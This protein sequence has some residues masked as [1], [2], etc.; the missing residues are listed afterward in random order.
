MSERI[1]NDPPL[2]AANAVG[3][4]ERL[5]PAFL[6]AGLGGSV[7][8]VSGGYAF[9][10][11]L[12]V[13]G[14]FS[15]ALIVGI[16]IFIV[17]I[18]SVF[19]YWRH[20]EFRVGANEIRIDSGIFSRTHRSIPFDRIQDVDISQGVLARLFGIA[21]VKLETGGSSGP[22]ADEGVLQ[23]IPLKRAEDLR[24][25]IRLR[26][27]A[28]PAAVAAETASCTAASEPVYRMGIKRLLLAGTFNFSLALFAG[29]F[30][31]T[32]TMGDFMGFDPLSAA[33]WQ[34][35][36]STGDPA[37]SFILAHQA[38][39]VIAGIILLV[40][41][42]L[43]TGIIRTVVRDWGFRLDRTEVGLRRRR[44]LTTITDV[45]L[46]VRRVQAAIMAS[47]PLRQALGYSE[48]RVQT[49]GHD[50]GSGNHVVAP[51]A[52]GGETNAIVEQLGWRGLPQGIPWTRVSSGYI[53]SL[54]VGLTPLYLVLIVQLAVIQYALFQ[55]Q[56][57]IRAIVW[58]EMTPVLVSF[59]AVLAVVVFAIGSR[60]LAWRTT[61]YAIDGDRLLVRMGWWKKRI[62]LLPLRRIQSITLHESFVT[63][64]FGIASLAFGVAGGRAGRGY[65][66]PAIPREGAR[67]LR[68]RLLDVTP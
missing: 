56:E 23:A 8:A 6:I 9:L 49:L 67:G 54:M 12:I 18:I 47:G 22:K 34:S 44:G 40:L 28:A 24:N 62:T 36:L 10:A 42:G 25:L 55:V 13:S 57:N 59:F 17:S 58:A 26:R 38:T 45:T 51:L 39:A 15:T 50:E 7:R 32:Q 1:S 53:W 43:V 63:R 4:V 64:R 29:L 31:L 33:F 11:Y 61:A 20:F 14:R 2:P 52:T 41:I 48:L 35:V 65:S 5:H 27:G 16:G 21:K 19:V 3:P 37:R 68:D 66:V 30:G 60:A 46:A